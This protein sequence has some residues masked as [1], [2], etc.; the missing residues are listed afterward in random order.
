MDTLGLSTQYKV[1]H[2]SQ[3]QGDTEFY[4]NSCKRDLCLQCKE[5]HVIDLYT[6]YHDV[7]IYREKFEYL[8]KQ[9]PALLYDARKQQVGNEQLKL[10]FTPVLHA[11]VCV[12]GVGSVRYISRV[13]SDRVWVSHICN[14]ILTDTTGGTIH[15]VKGITPLYGGGLHT[16]NSSGELIYIDSEYNINKLSI[17]NETVTKFLQRPL[18]WFLHCVYCS[19]STG[20]LMVGMRNYKTGKVTRYNS[21]GQ[22]ILTIEHDNTGH[23]LYNEPYCITENKN[24][25]I[26]VS[27][28]ITL[29][30]GAVVV[31]DRGGRHRFS[32]TGPPS[33]SSLD[34]RGICT[35]ALSHILVC[36]LNT[37]TV[38]M[39]DKEGHFLS[40]LLIQQHGINEPYSLNYD[41]K[42]HFLW[43]GSYRTNT[44]SVY[45]YLQR[46]YSLTDDPVDDDKM[47]FKSTDG[48]NIWEGTSEKTELELMLSRT[49]KEKKD[50]IPVSAENI[51]G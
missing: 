6:V 36:D 32:Y 30:C 5:K 29:Y 24:G 42:T 15:R 44:V 41:D 2:C 4:C 40:T 23:T 16:V 14:I 26:I 3:C 7:V 17:D 9:E 21:S 49:G 37:R 38:Q 20:D 22:H 50:K 47:I 43:V 12:K 19:L 39:I 1:R 34:P 48:T 35:D 11:S 51:P 28:W 45:R 46:R 33:G 31:T 10:I 25:D 18:P 13:M 8:P 27:D